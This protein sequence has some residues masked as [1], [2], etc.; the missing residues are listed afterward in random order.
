MGT[1]TI[2]ASANRDVEHLPK[3]KQYDFDADQYSPVASEDARQSS[4][5]RQR[6]GRFRHHQ[7]DLCRWG[8]RC[9]QGVRE[10]SDAADGRRSSASPSWAAKPSS[11][12]D[13]V[14]PPRGHLA[15]RGHGRTDHMR[16][17]S[18]RGWVFFRCQT[19]NPRW[20]DYSMRL[21]IARTS[22]TESLPG[23][24]KK[25]ARVRYPRPEVHRP[26]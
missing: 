16:D 21:E 15:I 10:K 2:H 12:V 4:G 7:S 26:R 3:T 24:G 20:T 23:R 5:C 1:S 22:S 8:P 17:N 6:P 14:A 11:H 19:K 25:V 13:R 18:A 9:F